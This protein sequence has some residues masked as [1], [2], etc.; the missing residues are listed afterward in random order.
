MAALPWQKGTITRTYKYL[1]V[2]KDNTPIRF[3]V[4]RQKN[5]KAEDIEF[6]P[7]SAENTRSGVTTSSW[8]LWPD[9]KD[10]D[11]T[12]LLK[13]SDDYPELK[14]QVL[15]VEISD[16]NSG[17]TQ[18]KQNREFWEHFFAVKQVQA[19]KAKAEK[20]QKDFALGVLT[21]AF[22][23][24]AVLKIASGGLWLGRAAGIGEDAVTINNLNR[25]N[26]KKGWF[27]VVVHGDANAPGILFN[28]NGKSVNAEGLYNL[29]IQNGYTK[30]T[31]IRLIAC[32][33]AQGGKSSVAQELS[34]LSGAQV[35]APAA[36]TR[37]AEGGKLITEDG[38]KYKVFNPVKE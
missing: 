10:G 11:F 20:V 7:N 26:P 30:G 1:E 21:T 27:D 33:A 18:H 31:R 29:M 17:N 24:L 23:E 4:H 15:P 34:N 13:V 32:N 25:L 16:P 12:S 9:T 28:V 6:Y 19:D 38:S 14:G 36:R 8:Y 22:A 3:F 2:I 37:V 5:G 35:V